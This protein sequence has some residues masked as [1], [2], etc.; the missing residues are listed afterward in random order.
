MMKVA[1]A[2]IV[3]VVSAMIRGETV[4]KI[5]FKYFCRR[6]VVK[7]I[8]MPREDIIMRMVIKITPKKHV[9]IT[10]RAIAT[11]VYEAEEVKETKP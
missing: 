3:L 5:S 10:R 1:H 11:W 8:K 2:K 4:N 6:V 9:N 7:K